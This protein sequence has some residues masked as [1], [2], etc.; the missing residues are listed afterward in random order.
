MGMLDWVLTMDPLA[1]CISQHTL[2]AIVH[3]HRHDQ[4]F[5]K[6]ILWISTNIEQ[7]LEPDWANGKRVVQHQILHN[8]EGNRAK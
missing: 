2:Q 5:N 6:T 1:G 7:D 8:H 3:N 4:D